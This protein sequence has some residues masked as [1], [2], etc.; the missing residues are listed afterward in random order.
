MAKRSVTIAGHRTSISLEA[1]FWEGL[2]ELAAARGESLAALIAAIDGR[3]RERE[4][5]S[6][7]IRV[8]VLTAQRGAPAAGRN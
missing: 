5:L 2:R 1:E 4:S 6:S 3:R 7:A 8:F